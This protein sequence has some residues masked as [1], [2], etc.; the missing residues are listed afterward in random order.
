MSIEKLN[1]VNENDEIIGEEDRRLIHEKGLLHR[2]VHVWFYTPQ[3]E[4]IFQHRAKDKDAYPDRLD[5]TVGGHVD[6]GDSYE[7]AAI[8]E[9]KEETGINLKPADLVFLKKIKARSEDAVTHMI[10]YAFKAEYAYLFKGAPE[11]LNIEEG[12]SHGFE[13]WNIDTL[14]NLPAQERDKFTPIIFKEELREI[15][16]LI[17]K[18]SNTLK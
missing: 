12:K 17:Q 14:L 6:I 4:V 13:L 16:I 9:S 18:L 7:E 11:D 15:F 3:G 5:A 1:V 2:E 8:R 10:N